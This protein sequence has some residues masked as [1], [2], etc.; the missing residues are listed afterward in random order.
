MAI[1]ANDRAA[2]LHR[3][4]KQDPD[5][6]EFTI[7]H[8]GRLTC[9]VGQISEPPVILL[10]QPFFENISV[11]RNTQISVC[12]GRPV[13]QRGAHAIVTDA[14]RDAVD[15]DSADDE[16]RERRTAKPC[17]PDPPT[18]GSSWRK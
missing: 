5:V 14:G 7:G 18:L 11:F 10:V 17:G 1:C 12:S 9:L 6:V 15:A 16:R 13:P 8:R 4:P 3:H 2:G